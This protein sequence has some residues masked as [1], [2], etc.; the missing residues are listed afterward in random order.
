MIPSINQT[1]DKVVSAFSRKSSS[2]AAEKLSRIKYALPAIAL[3]AALDKDCFG[4]KQ[5]YDSNPFGCD[6][7]SV[8][9]LC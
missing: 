8:S 2:G 4:A 7:P 1:F 6:S 5:N 9:W 3:P